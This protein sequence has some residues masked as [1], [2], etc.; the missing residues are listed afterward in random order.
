VRGAGP[1]PFV[2][3]LHDGVPVQRRHDEVEDRIP[4]ALLRPQGRAVAGAGV[5]EHPY[6][7]EACRAGRADRE[8]ADRVAYRQTGDVRAWR[9]P[10]PEAL[11]VPGA[12]VPASL[13]GAPEAALGAERDR[14]EEH[15]SELQ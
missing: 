8:P 6:A 15:T 14:S 11:A 10:G 9:A 1:L 3:G 12:H 5:R 7:L 2:Q 13:P 4:V